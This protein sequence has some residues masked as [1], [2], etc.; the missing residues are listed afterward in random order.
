MT[1]PSATA[2]VDAHLH[3]WDPSRT[4]MAWLEDMPALDRSFHVGHYREELRGVADGPEAAIFVETAVDDESLAAELDWIASLLG[5]ETMVRGAVAGWRPR[6]DA[7]ATGRR[8]DALAGIGGVVGVREVL[9]PPGLGVAVP[10]EPAMVAAAREAGR[11]GLVVDLCV[12]PDQLDA[13]RSLVAAA[14]ETAFVLDHLGRPS[15]SDPPCPAWMDAL[16]RISEQANV[17][18]KLSALIEC[19][20]G[21]PWTAAGFQPFV[22]HALAVFGADRVIWGSNWPVCRVGGGLGDWLEATGELLAPLE[23]GERAKVLGG[24]ALR[25]YGL[26]LD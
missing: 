22:D 6:G 20:G 9:H 26:S 17:S 14:P 15:T 12:R 25:V 16:G 2:F 11:R 4:S 3:A 5:D 1:D 24:N 8:L 18:T 10:G 13:A 21:R 19:A 7:S 23:P